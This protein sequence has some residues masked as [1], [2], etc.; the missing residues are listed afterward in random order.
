MILDIT[1]ILI[2]IGIGL[3]AIVCVRVMDAIL[4]GLM[5]KNK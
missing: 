4:D 1:S 2:G 5:G 3:F